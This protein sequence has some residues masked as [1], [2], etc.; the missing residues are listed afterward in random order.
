MARYTRTP[1]STLQGINN[2][3]A[4]VELAMQD[5]LDRTGSTPNYMDDNLDMNSRRILNLPAPITDQEPMRKGD[6]AAGSN[7]SLEYVDSKFLPTNQYLLSQGLSGAFNFFEEGF[8]YSQEGDVGI[9]ADGQMWLYVGANAP[10]KE[11][12]PGTVPSAPDY[13]KVILSTLFLS[14][15]SLK[16]SDKLT[17]LKT[18]TTLQHTSSGVGG[19]TYKKDGTTGTANTGDEWKFYDLNGDGW[20][21]QDEVLRLEQFGLLES[22]APEVNTEVLQKVADKL[23]VEQIPA[24]LPTGEYE[25]LGPVTF[26]SPSFDWTFY[27]GGPGFKLC[28][29]INTATD[30]SNGIELVGTNDTESV[31]TKFKGFLVQG[32]SNSG[33]GFY[34]EL[35]GR[36][37]FEEVESSDNGRHG[38][39]YQNSWAPSFYRC[40]GDRNALNGANLVG[41]TDNKI[42]GA[43]FEGGAYSS[44]QQDGIYIEASSADGDADSGAILNVGLS[45]NLRYGIW[46]ISPSIRIQESFPEFNRQG[47]IKL[48]SA[49][50]DK[51]QVCAQIVNN[52]L[53]GWNSS[54]ANYRCIIIEESRGIEIEGN[55]FNQTTTA[56]EVDST[57]SFVG[58]GY[59]RYSGTVTNVVDVD[60]D[61]YNGKLQVYRI[62]FD[63]TTVNASE[64]NTVDLLGST[65]GIRENFVNTSGVNSSPLKRWQVNGSTVF[66]IRED[67]RFITGGALSTGGSPS[68]IQNKLEVFDG[69][70]SSLGWIPLYANF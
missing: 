62:K 16:S 67:G 2:E 3:L 42:N 15:A 63:T 60:G 49:A 43:R 7:V 58:I 39:D 69:A 70:G 30:G 25:F 23:E 59:N 48:G 18:A 28:T 40:R 44:N 10:Y 27:L 57:S 1:I 34:V 68:T 35:A 13:N 47:Q 8:T 52:F 11:V 21:N 46:N 20:Q 65:A 32:N 12:A 50:N 54:G 64:I 37:E 31:W 22:N 4:K 66:G 51:I 38:Y 9:D 29:L 33:S 45:N 61:I 14:F 53:S 6:L 26:T 55:N 41:G 36:V 17:H 56:I 19:A 5:T 24:V